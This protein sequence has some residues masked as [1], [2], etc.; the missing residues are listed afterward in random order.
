MNDSRRFSFAT[1]VRAAAW[2]LLL[3]VA[4]FFAARLSV[5][6]TFLQSQIGLVWAPNAL[7]LGA[8]VLTPRKS[9]WMPLTA[10]AC[11][12][13]LALGPWTRAWMLAWQ[14]S[15]NFVCV[16]AAAEAL[17]SLIGFPL[18]FETRRNVLVFAATALGAS[19]LVGVASP[20]FI[21]Q[22]LGIDVYYAADVALLRLTLANLAPLLLVTPAIV[23]FAGLPMPRSTGVPQRRWA[24]IGT[25]VGTVLVTSLVALDTR[26]AST[27]LPWLLLLTFPPLTWAAVRLGPAGASL[28]L[29]LVG[30]LSAFGSMLHL[31]VFATTSPVVTVLW[32]EVYWVVIAPPTML[33][34]ATIAER[35]SLDDTLHDLRHQLAHAARVAAASE[36]SVTIAHELRQPMTA[37]LANAQAGLRLMARGT[38][39]DLDEVRVIFEEIAEQDK[40]A[41]DVIRGMRTLLKDVPMKREVIGLDVVVRDAL[42]LTRPSLARAGIEV[43]EHIPS[44]LPRV[45]GDYVQLT[46][47]VVNLVMNGCDS[48]ANLAGADR[49]LDVSIGSAGS[50][51]VEVS[52]RDSGIGLPTYGEDRVFEPFF[53]TKS[54]GLGLGLSV[55]R[56]IASAHGGRLW[57]ENN[58]RRHGATFHFELPAVADVRQPE[59]V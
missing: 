27:P 47:V 5:E 46:Q 30:A 17:R 14:I 33:L 42:H 54:D 58:F 28:S 56:S 38:A 11:S 10:A 1:E 12:H 6:F 41:A 32:I 37:I 50:D 52:V 31:G 2:A 29:L 20:A 44:S 36:L 24:E 23:L 22:L 51:R 57:A 34:A 49:V 19:L 55:G 43:Q 25:I 15:V 21:R 59:L 40:R 8:L 9:W 13:V 35:N 26:A 48:M 3:G 4:Y 45:N 16:V 39:S 7:V 18:R 53:T